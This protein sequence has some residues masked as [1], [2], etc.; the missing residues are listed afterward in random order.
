MGNVNNLKLQQFTIKTVC[1]CLKSQTVKF[2]H[3]LIRQISHDMNYTNNYGIAMLT[4][5]IQI[6][7]QEKSPT[8]A[9]A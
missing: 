1:K 2:L 8:T 6:E 4:T 9:V 7:K 3:L 5:L